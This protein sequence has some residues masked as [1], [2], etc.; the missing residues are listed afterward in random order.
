MTKTLRE[1]LD[2]TDGQR[3][4]LHASGMTPEGFLLKFYTEEYRR[5]VERNEPFVEV[6]IGNFPAFLEALSQGGSP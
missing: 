2:F 3:E 5:A 4:A 6:A 1:I